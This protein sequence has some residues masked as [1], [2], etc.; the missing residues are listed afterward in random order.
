MTATLPI[1]P[2]IRPALSTMA[3]LYDQTYRRWW[4]YRQVSG[5]YHEASLPRRWIHI[6]YLGGHTFSAHCT[7][8]D[9]AIW[10]STFTYDPLSKQARGK[11][12][13]DNGMNPD[14]WGEHY[15]QFENGGARCVDR[16][17]G[18]GKDDV[19]YKIHWIRN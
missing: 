8:G 5:E 4:K 12:H 17:I 2:I 18:G 11:Y 13:Y 1:G 6:D 16:N 19:Q 14:D 10:T 3:Y 7:E 9:V 15:L